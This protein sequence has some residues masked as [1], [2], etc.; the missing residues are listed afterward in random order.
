MWLQKV[1]RSTALSQDRNP[2]YLF[3]APNQPRASIPKA[4]NSLPVSESLGKTGRQCR[5]Q[6]RTCGDLPDS[7]ELGFVNPRHSLA[8]RLNHRVIVPH[9][10][11]DGE[12][13]GGAELLS[14]EN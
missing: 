2:L 10:V 1:I 12:R 14:T 11:T 6:S 3:E 9:E 8:Q 4:G 13:R 5:T 7:R